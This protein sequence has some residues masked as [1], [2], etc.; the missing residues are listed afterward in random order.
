MDSSFT[1]ID[2]ISMNEPPETRQA[3]RDRHWGGVPG[4]PEV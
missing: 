3:G 1:F 2:L 4:I